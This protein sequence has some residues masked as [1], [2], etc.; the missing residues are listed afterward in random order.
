MQVHL[1]QLLQF[2]RWTSDFNPIHVDPE[3]ARH[4]YFGQ[5]VVHGALSV[6]RT[7]HD[8]QQRFPGAADPGSFLH[9]LEVEFRGAAFPEVDCE[10]VPTS[11]GN[12]G[13][14]SDCGIAL[15]L[16]VVDTG[17]VLLTLNGS[18]R[19]TESADPSVSWV[20]RYVSNVEVVRRTTPVERRVDE[21]VPGFEIGGVWYAG[22]PESNYLAPGWI[23][24]TEARVLGLTSYLI[25]MELPGLRSLFSRL[26]LTFHGTRAGGETEADPWLYRLR[27]LRYDRR[28]RILDLQL[29]VATRDHRL[30]ASGELRSYVRFSPLRCDLAELASFLGDDAASLEGKVALVCGGTRGLG[31][32]LAAGFALAGCHVY[33][34]HR[35][36]SADLAQ[37]RG[38]VHSRGLEIDFLQGN[39]ADPVWCEQTIADIIGHRGRLDFLVLNACAPPGTARVDSVGEPQF[40]AYV[41]DNL[42]LVSAPLAAGLAPLAKSGGAIVAISSSAIDDPPQG[43]AHYVA[44]KQAMEG[45]VRTSLRENPAVAALLVRPPKL[46]TS[47]NDT[48]TRVLGALPPSWVVAEVVNRLGRSWKPGTSEL[49][50]DFP[51]PS[52]LESAALTTLDPEFS[53]IVSAT[54]T[55]DP[56]LKSLRFWFQELDV[57]GHVELAAYGQVLQQLLDPTSRLA[58]NSRGVGVV[59]VR[60]EDW[61]RELPQEKLESPK[62]LS[63]YLTETANEL[64]QALRSHRGIA[65]TETIVLLCPSGGEPTCA[66]D[67]SLIAEI[68]SR[69]IASLAAIP[70]LRVRAAAEFHP[71]Y[72]VDSTRIHDPLR[73]EIGHIPYQP[74]YF[75]FLGTVVVRLAYRQWSA[76]RKVVVVDCDNTLWRGVVGEVGP[77]GVEFDDSHRALHDALRRLS[78]SGMLV[79]LCSK[80][81]EFDVWNVF[82]RRSDF[83][84]PRSRIVGAM[85]NWLP[86]SQNLKTLASRLNLGIDSFVFLDDNP[87][88]CGEVRSA[89]PEVLTLNFP[90]RS[91]D[92][93]R[94]LRHLWELDAT[95]GTR[96][97]LK[98]TQMYQEELQ[99]VE[100]RTR[101]GSFRDFI[102]SLNLSVEIN[103]LAPDDVTR[104]SQLTLRT[105]Q[106][107]FLTRRRDEVEIQRLLADEK[108]R[109]STVHVTDRFGD[110][111]LVGLLITEVQEDCLFV[112]SFLLSC[113]VLGRGVE[114]RMAAKVGALAR[115]Q[116]IATVRMRVESTK[117]NAPARNFLDS[118]SALGIRRD[119]GKV[120]ECD[121]PAA[122]L[123]NLKWEPDES[124]VELA[125]TTGGSPVS[126]TAGADVETVRRRERQISRAAFELGTLAELQQ[127]IDGIGAEDGAPSEAPDNIAE[128]VVGVFAKSLR[129]SPETVRQVD[130][131]EALGCGSFK[132]VEIT[133]ELASRFPWL[134]STLLFEHRNVSE[135]VHQITALGHQRNLPREAMAGAEVA[136]PK[137][138]KTAASDI[139]IVGIGV[140]CAGADSPEELWDL[141]LGGRTAIVEVPCDRSVFLSRLEDE[142]TH[143]AG[144]VEG[145]QG[146][147]A[148]FFGISPREAES[149]DPQLRLFLETAWTALE[150]AGMTG[151]DYEPDT[152]VFVGMI[153]GD[154]VHGANAIARESGNP[155][156][157]WE[158]FSTAN[159][160]SQLLG[161]R[162]P[163]LTVDTACSSSGTALHLA[164]RAISDG[165]CA[166][167]VVGGMNLILDPQRFVQLGQLGILS[168]SG[169][170]DAFGSEADGT[171]LGEGVGVVVLRRL[172]DALAR[173]ER[174]Y[175]VIRGS[176]LSSGN[177]TIGFTAPNPVAQ[178]E[179]MR[180]AI[181]DSHIDPRTI[182]YIETHGTGT[183]LGDPIEVRG[184][185]LA[186]LD[187]T[188]WS[189][190]IEGGW[191]CALGSIKPNIGHLEAGAGVVGLIKI[192]LQMHH[193]TLVPTRTSAR[194]NPQ[195]PFD[196]LPFAVQREAVPWVAPTLQVKGIPTTLPLRAALNSF[197][198]GGANS[199][200][201]LEEAPARPEPSPSEWQRPRHLFVLSARDRGALHGQVD[202]LRSWLERHPTIDLA[203][204]GF[205]LA[206][207]RRHFEHRIALP[208]E[209]RTQAMAALEQLSAGAAPVG[210]STGTVRPAVRP[211]LAFLFT[212]QG[213]QYPG[214]GRQ[215]YQ[216]HPVFREALDRC[217][218]IL[219]ELLPRRF[220]DVLFA[221]EGS[222]DA[223]LIHQTGYTQ[224]ALF[225][226]EFALAELWRSWGVTPDLVM[227]HSIG[228]HAAMVVAGGMSLEDGLRLI[229]ARGR[230]MQALPAG[231]GMLSVM[232]SES[233]TTSILSD[234]FPELSIAA[235]NGPRQTVVS[236]D[237][238]ALARLA[239]RLEQKGVRSKKLSV[240][241][242]FHSVLME[243][244]LADYAVEAARVRLGRPTIP[245]V[246][247]SLGRLADGELTDPEYWVR[248]VRSPVR[249]T[250]AMQALADQK[251]A[252]FLETGPHPVML[253]MGQECLTELADVEAWLPSLRRNVDP[254]QTILSSLGG[255]YTRNCAI[256]WRGFDAPW[257]R[258]RVA[259]PAYPF[260]QTAYWIA[261]GASARGN[262]VDAGALPWSSLGQVDSVMKSLAKGGRFSSAEMELI[263]RLL[264]ALRRPADTEA[265]RGQG[266]DRLLYEVVW[267]NHPLSSDA[268]PASLVGEWLILARHEP[269]AHRLAT[270]IANLGA[271]CRVIPTADFLNLTE[272]AA[273]SLLAA[274]GHSDVPL[275]IVVATGSD[276]PLGDDS[277][278]AALA[279]CSS[280]LAA[281]TRLLQS[282]LRSPRSSDARLWIVTRAAVAV[283]PGPQADSI[284]PDQTAIWGLGRTL[285]L[286]HP[287][288]WGGLIDVAPAVDPESTT[289]RLLLEMTTSGSED[290]VALRADGRYL[291]RL[292]PLKITPQAPGTLSADGVYL[293]TGGMGALGLRMS[294]WL[295]ARGA[296]R[297]VLASRRGM[298]SAGAAEIVAELGRLGA[299]AEVVALDVGNP[300]DF[301]TYLKELTSRHSLKGIIHAAGVDLI[302]PL[303]KT[304]PSSLDQ[305]LSPKLVGGTILDLQTRGLS[306]DLFVCFSSIS[307]T[308]G[309]NGRGFYGAANAFLD[310]LILERRRLGLPGL[311]VAWGP[312]RG[313]GMASQSELDQYDRMG[314]HGLDPEAAVEALDRLVAARVPQAT[315]ADIDWE[316]FRGVYAARRSRPLIDE[317]EATRSSNGSP[318]RAGTS[319]WLA[320]LSAESEDRRRPLLLE[321]LRGEVART[322]GL[323][324]PAAVSEVKTFYEMGMDSLLAT[325][326]AARLGKLIGVGNPGL[327]FAHPRLADLTDHLLRIA[328]VQSPD[329]V[330]VSNVDPARLPTI[331]KEWVALLKQTAVAQR[332]TRLA[333]LLKIEVAQTLGLGHPSQVP[334]DKTF[335]EMGL[336]SLLATDFAN[337]LFRRLGIRNVALVFTHPKVDLLA[338]Q[339]VDLLS[340]PAPGEATPAVATSVESTSEST[341]IELATPETKPAVMQFLESEF[342]SRDRR[343]LEAR[344]VWLFIDS[345]RRLAT[346]PRVWIHREGE[347]VIGHLGAIPID[348]QIGTLR[349]RTA[350]LVDNRVSEDRR[351]RAIGPQLIIQ[352]NHDLPLSLSLGQTE[353]IRKILG[354]L[355]WRY[356]VP[357]QTAMLLLSPLN[358][359][360][361]K[362][363]YPAAV[364]A[365]LVLGAKIAARQMTTRVL[366][367]REHA[368]AGEV[369]QVDRFEAR[370][371]RL[372]ER[373]SSDV[374]CAS[375]RDS[376][377]LNWKW[378]SQP[379]QTPYR[380]EIV[381]GEECL[382]VA[383]LLIREPD[384]VYSYRRA[385]L[386]D[387]VMPLSQ[388]RLVRSLLEAAIRAARDL[389]ADSLICL[390]ANAVLTRALQQLGFVIRNPER[391][392]MIHVNSP[393]PEEAL[394][395]LRDGNN[396]FLTQADSDIDRP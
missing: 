280:Q 311:S 261:S 137:S 293:V 267:R 210:S 377:F 24:P 109:I 209:S 265:P 167:A 106:F 227:G 121:F 258:S 367:M 299:V 96:E 355:G 323:G 306:L 253:G 218:L 223:D 344:W 237:I 326:F 365:S 188:L 337:R 38:M 289:R 369:R 300:E 208:V 230:L 22:T 336:D 251:A 72:E 138:S 246:S 297:L 114:H 170:C 101:A 390:H 216:S 266:G 65:R 39:V 222:P 214:M 245:F 40:A 282:V 298:Q 136:D 308:L 319:T 152:G 99:R 387:L 178:A 302:S 309:S 83:N 145:I 36:E 290:Q 198:I 191:G 107:N 226:I 108:W 192:L 197:G 46:L 82:D 189:S 241:H 37:F 177:G 1:E 330:A 314:N 78:D 217:A 153:Y 232:A 115:D 93:L 154:Y 91:E 360:R 250:T 19:T 345:A 147:D 21:L 373:M 53:I 275:R 389:G 339:L 346:E 73:D 11:S 171:L 382:G 172:D 146:F 134:P 100:S 194:L 279:C 204:V 247:S 317:I 269:F 97:D 388:P 69:L 130:Q 349:Q 244:M 395:Q 98:R 120:L 327:V 25:G 257:P 380:I 211:K 361:T 35:G 28:F 252:V 193:R 12:A 135:I 85:I 92:A 392:L 220:F 76:L 185:E 143:W 175:G 259:L 86:K 161:F 57:R 254:W 234:D 320:Q 338:R 340:L 62:F 68:E 30:V 263:P 34:T 240:S 203:D 358:V 160:L 363:P 391:H 291:P 71:Q 84:L 3:A 393:L 224:P 255:L 61:L 375:V 16:R 281:I 394:S 307:A 196:A 125:D 60:V 318:T 229:A 41:S 296:R 386:A 278:E 264:E 331:D 215:L 105:N 23:G 356:V 89:A 353:E 238:V 131:L 212:G 64:E 102:D 378:V 63:G 8:Y 151:V 347:R 325:Q 181:K 301:S 219:D 376:S 354:H 371:D 283:H 127:A 165:E 332:A 200:V 18:H 199:H 213:A 186:Y 334:T 44:L 51:E 141:L 242:A 42:K 87:V 123:T 158:G 341:P 173:G 236:G 150:D 2:A 5:N 190:E 159:R 364:T 270:Q 359:L 180:K 169:K 118:I 233:E 372:W 50:T 207:S 179:A 183:Q 248:Q 324:S 328:H 256:D 294:K 333:A 48:P 221:V 156:R 43:W 262:P 164:S 305:V 45:L 155:Y 74:A 80:N 277:A 104:A 182:S 9:T 366:G 284:F 184:L 132:I 374:C 202:R 206:A 315:V 13:G 126:T 379:G 162:G 75:H 14:S 272:D 292:V 352:A 381:D 343:V 276:R 231:G 94:L 113:R 128:F 187:P 288:L 20:P 287:A 90:T 54:F 77:E 168:P 59:L 321:L 10:V 26:S 116:S 27:V 225:A 362:M 322:I 66:V 112:D 31:A 312:W 139:A 368:P 140:R 133:V 124:A 286:E 122:L 285:A 79:C 142:R 144:L 49:V 303:S 396:W 260:S 95:V 55:A 357:L 370:H 7:L 148:D 383:V 335:F 329:K 81:E 129:I 310:G 149:L 239:A 32:E 111:G 249:F 176:G 163:S 304:S 342:Q 56:I 174:I 274:S 110:Y 88:E 15:E 273:A 119:D 235:M 117:R 295:I 384:T 4:T 313:G 70:G 29:E 52:V 243:P 166:A 201:I 348:L 47:W 33:S 67:S 205:S 17:E 228:E 103:S 316:T 157:C 195:I 58:T 350:W 268:L 351:G 385:F 271:P 6:V